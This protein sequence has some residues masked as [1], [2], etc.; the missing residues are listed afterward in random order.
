MK[1]KINIIL[2]SCRCAL[3]L[4]RPQNK[5]SNDIYR[6]RMQIY[7]DFKVSNKVG[8]FIDIVIV[9]WREFNYLYPGVNVVK[10]LNLKIALHNCLLVLDDDSFVWVF[11]LVGWFG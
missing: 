3:V 11:E 10:V 6:S 5:Y 2:A 1:R 8:N 9:L 4:D 7:S